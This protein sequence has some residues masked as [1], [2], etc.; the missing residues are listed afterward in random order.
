MFAVPPGHVGSV[1][2]HIVTYLYLQPHT[3]DTVMVKRGVAF[4]DPEIPDEEF[5][6][7]VGLFEQ[8]MAEDMGQLSALQKGLKSKSAQTAPL[9]PADYEGNVGISISI[10]LET[11]A[12]SCGRVFSGVLK[13][14][15]KPK[16]RRGE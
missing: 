5:K 10:W 4:L 16:G 2:G 14:V 13:I 12:D 3:P 1:T 11:F 7:A 15:F 9:A 8:T 6:A